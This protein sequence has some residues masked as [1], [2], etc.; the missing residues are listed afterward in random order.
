MN[1]NDLSKTRKKLGLTQVEVANKANISGTSYQRI[2]YRKQRPS[3]DTAIKIA[4]ILG[5][6]DLREIF[7]INEKE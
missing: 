3:L 4:D 7:P 6:V 2:E 1:N 5:I